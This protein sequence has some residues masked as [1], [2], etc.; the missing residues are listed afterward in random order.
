MG[1][2]VSVPLANQLQ[3]PFIHTRGIYEI[4]ERPSHMYSWTAL[5]TSQILAELPWNLLGS[6]VCTSLL[7]QTYLQADSLPFRSFSSVGTGPLVSTAAGPASP[8]SSWASWFRCTTPESDSQSPPCRRARRS[9]LCC[10]ASC[11][12]L[13]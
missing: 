4:R 9:R 10:S 13:C 12:P 7:F 11:S 6:S 5:V 1:L 2:I 8:T 3:V